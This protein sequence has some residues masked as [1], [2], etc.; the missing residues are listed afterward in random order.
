[1]FECC[2]SR[3]TSQSERRLRFALRVNWE[4]TVSIRFGDDSGVGS[5]DSGAFSWIRI[6]VRSFGLILCDDQ[7]D[8]I[9][10][11]ESE[12]FE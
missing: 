6:C 3:A 8:R 5:G 12:R 4:E 11:E 7:I 1:V 2:V 10:F 9:R